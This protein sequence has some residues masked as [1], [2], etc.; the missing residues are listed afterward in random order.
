MSKVLFGII[1]FLV[2]VLCGW[3]IVC[4]LFVGGIFDD[5]NLGDFFWG[6][7]WLYYN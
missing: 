3:G 7:I 1:L 4:F 5:L 2:L 6:D